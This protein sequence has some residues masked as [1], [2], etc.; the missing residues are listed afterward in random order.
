MCVEGWE[1]RERERERE[2]ERERER[3]SYISKFNT[4]WI[5]NDSSI[6]TLVSSVTYQLRV[7]HTE[8][9]IL[10]L[11]WSK[12]SDRGSLGC[13][14]GIECEVSVCV[15][16]KDRYC[17]VFFLNIVTMWCQHNKGDN[18]RHMVGILSKESNH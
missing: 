5:S 3:L 16:V 13:G 14:E 15:S 1:V 17:T 2:G 10:L 4:G 9:C 11:P 12:H 6:L 18:S 8:I 7:P